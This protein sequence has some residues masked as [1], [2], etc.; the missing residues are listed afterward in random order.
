MSIYF[1]YFAVTEKPSFWDKFDKNFDKVVANVAGKDV[2]Q[3]K[4]VSERIKKYYFGDK[5]PS[6]ETLDSFIDVSIKETLKNV[7][8]VLLF[9]N[10]IIL[11][12]IIPTT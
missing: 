5:R 4:E 6:E 12:M 1:C 7:K 9:F 2:S 10:L 11:F 8:N 3:V